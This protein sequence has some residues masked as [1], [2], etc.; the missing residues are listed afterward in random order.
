M[1]DRMKTKSPTQ[2][3]RNDIVYAIELSKIILVPFPDTYTNLILLFHN[4]RILIEQ[5]INSIG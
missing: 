5:C 2:I 1:K 3:K 4:L